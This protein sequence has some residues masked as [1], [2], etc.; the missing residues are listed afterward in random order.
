MTSK[1]VT[2]Q[3]SQRWGNNACVEQMATALKLGL[4]TAIAEQAVVP[5]ALN[6]VGSTC[7]RKRRTDRRQPSAG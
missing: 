2:L 1:V 4:A 7:N 5:D 3:V 6:P